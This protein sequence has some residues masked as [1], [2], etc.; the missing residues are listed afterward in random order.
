MTIVLSIEVRQQQAT[1]GGDKTDVV[2]NNPITVTI[3]E[4]GLS[5][6]QSATTQAVS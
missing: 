4:I 1:E 3:G 6:Q 5:A 2:T